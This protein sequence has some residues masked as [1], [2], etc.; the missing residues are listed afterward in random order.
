MNTEAKLTYFS[1]NKIQC[2]VCESPFYREDL[3]TGRGRL[4][5]GDLTDELRRLY[6]PSGKFGVA[7][8]LI[9]PATVCPSCRFAAFPGDFLDIGEDTKHEVE[10]DGEK[11]L[12]N[13]SL[14]FGDLDF[15]EPRGLRE[16]A[17]SYYL[18]MMCYD[19]FPDEKSPTIKQGL[20]ALRA[21]WILNDLA[22]EEPDENYERVMEL[23]YRKARFFYN[24]AIEYEQSGKESIANVAHLGPDLDKNYG[25]DG[26]LYLSAYLELRYGPR[27]DRERRIAALKYAK[28]T[29]ARIFGMGKASKNKPSA[30]LDR[31]R[32]LY[33][34]LGEELARSG[35]DGDS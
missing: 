20:C 24:Q 35:E 4:I 13:I 16:G 30:I 18:S 14:L 9:Y 29:C 25:Y 5:A 31:A 23:F 26:V 6:D 12:H 8:P 10:S 7:N 15:H 2:P 34:Q 19:H 33:E 28:R 3:L 22:V 27:D 32:E 1:K 11:R 21:S 17:A